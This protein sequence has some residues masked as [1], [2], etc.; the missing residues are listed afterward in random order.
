MCPKRLGDAH[1]LSTQRIELFVRGYGSRNKLGRKV[2]LIH[3]FSFNQ[4][5]WENLIVFSFEYLKKKT[6][7]ST[8]CMLSI[9]SKKSL[10]KS[11]KEL[12][13]KFNS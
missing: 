7:D 6:T 4:T 11:P 12:T 2:W 3:N 5:N 13:Y 1:S 9:F 8:L 10:A